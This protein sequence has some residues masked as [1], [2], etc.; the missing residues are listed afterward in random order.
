MAALSGVGYFQILHM[1]E[2]YWIIKLLS[3]HE[4]LIHDSV[5]L[6][7]NYYTLKQIASIAQCKTSTI[8]LQLQ[9]VQME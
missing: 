2:D 7:P 5:Y 8:E 9:R 6:Q 3:D 1:G 4:V